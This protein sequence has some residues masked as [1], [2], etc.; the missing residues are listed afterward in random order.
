M[1]N[2]DTCIRTPV[3]LCIRMYTFT[4]RAPTEISA[5]N[6]LFPYHVCMWL[7]KISIC[8][9]PFFKI[10]KPIYEIPP[11]MYR[12]FEDEDATCSCCSHFLLTS[13]KYPCT[14]LRKQTCLLLRI[15]IHYDHYLSLVDRKRHFRE[16]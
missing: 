14:G 10:Q 16:I 4:F 6:S 3:R 9:P 15:C 7:V 11:G 13:S 8:K 2:V 1:L 12:P 5:L